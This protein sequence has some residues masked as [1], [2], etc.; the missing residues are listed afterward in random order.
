VFDKKLDCPFLSMMIMMLD[1]KLNVDC[2]I[3]L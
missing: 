3:F 1:K 2:P